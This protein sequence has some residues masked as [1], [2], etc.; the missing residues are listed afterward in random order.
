MLNQDTPRV[1][2]RNGTVTGHVLRGS[3]GE[4]VVGVPVIAY[5]KSGSQPGVNCPGNPT[6]PECA[7]ALDRTDVGGAFQFSP[8][9]AGQ[10][11]LSTFEQATF[12]QGEA[13][14]TLAPDAAVDATILFAQGLGTVDG[15]VLDSSGQ[16]VA[17]ARVGG[18]LSL[19][20]TDGSGHFRLTDVPIGHREIV[21]VSDALATTG[22]AAIDLLQA[23]Q[24]VNATIVL[25]GT[26]SV[27]GTVYAADGVTPQPGIKV[28]LFHTVA[29]ADGAGIN[30]DAVA[31]TDAA[32]HYSLPSVPLRNDYALSAFRA[33]FSDGNVK[34]VVLK[35]NHEVVRGDIVFRGGGG[36]IRGAVYDAD[37]VTPLRAAVGISGDQVV[38]AGG[39]VGTA[40][41]RVTNYQVTNTSFATGAFSFDG[42]FVGPFTLAAA[43]QFSP[44]PISFAGAIPSPGATVRVD[45]RLQAT[46]RIQ[47]TVLQPDG[48]TPVGANVL[49]RYTSKAFKVVCAQSSSVRVGA[50][51]IEPGSCQ[52]VP[53][54]I[55]DETVITDDQGRFLLPLVNAGSFTLTAE[56]PATGQ[57]GQAAGEVTPGQT[58]E[59]PVRLLRLRAVVVRVRG[60]DAVTPIPGARVELAQT[61]FP[62][63]RLTALA[64]AAGVV[65][66]DGGDSLSEGDLTVLATDLR[67]GFAGRATARVADGEGDVTV[68]VFLY[69]AAGS[70]TGRVFKSDGLTPVPNA[71]VVI[72]NDRGPL[73]LGIT[74]GSGDYRADL[75]PLGAFTVDVFEAATAR[76]GLA[77][78]R[79][80]FDRQVV[81]INVSEVGRGLVTGTLFE[82]GSLAALRGWDVA[83]DQSINTGR[84]VPPLRATSGVDGT[85][86]FPG[87]PVGDFRIHAGKLFAPGEPIG[88]ADSS[89]RLPGEGQRVDLPI[90]VELQRRRAGRLEGTVR[91]PDGTPAPN[92]AVDVCASDCFE[93]YN[94]LSALSDA[95]GAFAFDS[96]ALGRYTLRAR[97]QV[98]RNAATVYGTLAFE[99]DVSRVLLTL[100]GVTTISGE[101]VQG[102][103]R[104][105]AGAQVTL[106]GEPASGCADAGSIDICTGFADGNGRF[107]FINV[108]ARTFILTA[109][110][111][112]TGLKGVASG[113]VN[114]G[115][116]FDVRIAL[117]PTAPVSG[118]VVQPGGAPASGVTVGLSLRPLPGQ[119]ERH[120]FQVSDAG[121]RFT[122][123]AVALGTYDLTL[124]DPLSPGTARSVLVLAAAAQLGDILLDA[125]PP[126]VIA[127][128]PVPSS[129][130]VPRS[131]AIRVTFSEPVAAGT[132]TP[133]TVALTGPLGT[134]P[135]TLAL[136]SGDTV[137]TLTP[138]DALRDQ[139]R[140]AVSVL[141]VQDRIGHA[142]TSAYVASFTTADVLA[143]QVIEVSPGAGAVGVPRTT[144]VRVKFSEPFDAVRF[145]GPPI[146]VLRAG[147]DV[148]GRTDIVFGG[149]TLVFT[150]LSPLL[151]GSEYE[152]QVAAASDAFGNV[153]PLGLVYRFMTSDGTPPGIA[154][155]SV[156]NGGRVIENAVAQIVPDLGTTHDVAVVDYFVNDQ[157]AAA[158]RAAPFGFNLQA[159]SSLGR[160][161]DTIK[162]SAF[163]TDTSGNRSL[164]P[165]IL[166]LTIIADQ[167]PIVRILAPA[168]DAQVRNGDRVAVTVQVTDD[169]GATQVGYR[170]QTGRPQDAATKSFALAVTDRTETFFF[171]VAADA[172]PGSGIQIQASA[173][174]ARGQVSTASP[175]TI[176]V[177]DATPPTVTIT[178][179]T[180][181]S[182]VSPGQQTSAVVSAQDLGGIR[183]ITFTAGGAA[184][185]TETRIID[186][187][188]ASAVGAFAFTVPLTARPG[189]TVTLDAVATDAA[190]NSTSAARV[191]LPVADLSPPTLRLRTAS[192]SSTIVTGS[193]VT[194]VAEGDDE[195]AVAS[196]ALAGEGAF[197]VAD[198]RQVTP[199]SNAA[200]IEFVIA[201]PAGL[202]AG[203][204]LDLSGVATDIFGNASA[205]TRLVL[206]VT[207]VAEVSLPPS[208]LIAAGEE[209]QVDVTL[210]APAP[211]GGLRIDLATGQAD[212]AV[213]DASVTIP[214]G[215]LS[216]SVRI[217][218]V[219]GGTT[220]L[221]A[222][223]AGTVRAL[224][225][226]VVR[227][228]V[229]TGVVL[230]PG[231]V[232]VAG[233]VV[234][235]TEG[236]VGSGRFRTAVTD[237]A[238][239]YSVEGINGSA[240][241][242]S[243]FVVQARD[244][245]TQLIGF[246]RGKLSGASG[247]ARQDVIL[248]PAAT[249]GGVVYQPGGAAPAGEGTRVDIF[250]PQDR[251]APLETAFTDAAGQYE[252]P[253]VTL[254]TYVLEASDLG[255]NRG[256]SAAL[257]LITTGQHAV[258]DITFLG[259]GVV[260]GRILNGTGTP[261]PNIAVTITASSLFGTAPD[262]TTTADGN[263]V[264]RADGVFVGSVARAG[265]ASRAATWRGAAAGAIDESGAGPDPRRP[266]GG[267][268]HGAG[269]GVPRRRDD[270]GGARRR[271]GDGLRRSARRHDRRA[272]SLHD[273]VRATRSLHPRGARARHSGVRPDDGRAR[274]RCARGDARR[275]DVPAGRGPGDGDRCERRGNR[276]RGCDG[277]GQ[278]RVR[279]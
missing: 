240:F 274:C 150:P 210:G 237:D 76:R 195:S 137:V 102:D 98:N 30:V 242:L 263:G 105:A 46:S 96:V 234:T 103:G 246:A 93:S 125:A 151:P 89:G 33:D 185:R 147:V 6:P 90:V 265:A 29:L 279:G 173:E 94:R 26:G 53:Q 34:P 228:G 229:V 56:D 9:A 188:L 114:P 256:R 138:L 20:V 38:V 238:G 136:G 123:D 142:M 155:L 174:D 273:S 100:V 249:V 107:T 271:V 16:P 75:I 101:V 47:G 243:D 141:G 88:F 97:S 104:P 118:R 262:I 59:L 182:R 221:T 140:Y 222:R 14:L 111:P 203:A 190:G 134:V 5:Y 207:T 11:R 245:L 41:Q 239:R 277:V 198:A 66:L 253:L 157:P 160:A 83:F 191:L 95:Q 70:V 68:D 7:V 121:G 132:V 244:P 127:L 120:L 69:N 266:A 161:G 65:R 231:L 196:I 35:F 110:D 272:G 219:G 194:I 130:Q 63:K 64:D 206:T 204:T 252:F 226:V 77:S 39:I 25:Q 45:L 260:T 159:V 184:V 163:A 92:V 8:I 275:R 27:A 57:A 255:G 181:G 170:A 248:L 85:F 129:V 169:L 227:G 211:A 158:V 109:V 236:Q 60:S 225:T 153:Q 4:P 78:G 254:G 177:L 108:P 24:V 267:V 73:A 156:A 131:V 116:P 199:P 19:T 268:G 50:L 117:E 197:T 61:E 37:G 224:M 264:Y 62:R 213:S 119:T 49:V 148:A 154:G 276:R 23:G 166:I 179:T 168:P 87:A 143:P 167:P 176:T 215:G 183:S 81:P 220:T 144:A 31:V 55:Q 250:D 1:V 269:H 91:N 124:D 13:R 200:R 79:I 52:D 202:A 171:N 241:G 258:A 278:H 67:N 74:D 193:S 82:S 36:H 230:S 22:S 223:V 212:I 72:S 251:R 172:V 232:P 115:Q 261:I 43:G 2:V 164:Q 3:G 12:Q 247:F 217:A 208:L 259:R 192:G 152:V 48:V 10:L 86:S 32:G 80:D 135:A 15:N 113:S 139:T 257:T 128:D 28:H 175:V 112:V 189:D 218:G 18:G 180:T 165:A 209:A 42:V 149:T 216:G 17:G 235:V 58:A 126:S 214:E 122:F 71:E 145:R 106:R 54:G 178:G 162:V 205:P 51:T 233:A 40:F 84:L 186:P 21:A 44:D 133:A 270:A 146:R 201:V 187:A 99:G